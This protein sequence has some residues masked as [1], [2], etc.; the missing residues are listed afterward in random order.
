MEDII[1]VEKKVVYSNEEAALLDIGDGIAAIE[2][3]SKGNSISHKVREFL[4]DVVE[5][6]LKGFD[7]AVIGNQSKHFSVGANLAGIKEGIEQ[8]DFVAY[9][10]RIQ[11]FQEMTSCI[12]YSSKPIVAAP[13][14]TALGGGLEVVMH[15]ARRVALNK[16]YLG[17]VEVG[18]GLIPGG[19][20]TKETALLIGDAKL[21]EQEAVMKSALKKLLLR[22]VSKNAGHALQMSY[23]LPMDVIVTE[24]KQLLGMA[25]MVCA[26]MVQEGYQKKQETAVVLPGKSGYDMLAGYTDEMQQNG[27]ISPYDAEIGKKLAKVLAGSDVDGAKTYSETELLALERQCFLDL[28]QQQG[29]YDRI[30]HFLATNEMLRN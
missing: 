7:G 10:K 11:L 22:E 30:C 17:L 16:C 29:T 14:R 20:G 9:E 8:K 24:Q 13:Y 4:T 1:L 19:G 25:K 21:E 26:D 18:V 6:G 15:A 2:F 28:V 3:R 27:E 12:K 23:L 5:S